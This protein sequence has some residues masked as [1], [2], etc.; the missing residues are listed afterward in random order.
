MS[1]SVSQTIAGKTKSE[2]VEVRDF[3]NYEIHENK[4]IRQKKNGKLLKGR[5]WMG[6]P[7]VTLMKDGKKHERRIHKL[8]GEH[9]IPNPD[10]L[11]IVNH[12]NSNRSDHTKKNLEWVNNSGNQ[13]HRWATQKAGMKK[14][15]YKPEYQK[16]AGS[17]DKKPFVKKMVESVTNLSDRIKSKPTTV[18]ATEA[19]S[20]PSI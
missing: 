18:T 7:K 19:M 3:K 6:Y 2:W 4:G 9:F 16:I 15:V 5:T 11:P 8:V 14:K 10:N 12:K 13:L 20:N 17:L 1:L